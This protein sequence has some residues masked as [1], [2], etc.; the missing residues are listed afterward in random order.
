MT[1]LCLFGKLA[2]KLRES[3]LIINDDSYQPGGMMQ[4]VGPKYYLGI[5]LCLTLLISS[6]NAEAFSLS[7]FD[8]AGYLAYDG[9]G[10]VV[11]R[12]GLDPLLSYENTGMYFNT[13][14]A[15]TFSFEYLPTF[16]SVEEILGNPATD[17]YWSATVRNLRLPCQE[18]A[19]PEFTWSYV[20]SYADLLDGAN[21]AENTYDQ[22]MP[23]EFVYDFGY[24]FDSET[25]GTA[26]LNLAANFD[27]SQLP[28]EFPDSYF[29]AYE[30]GLE[31]EVH[32]DPIPENPVPEPISLVM[33]GTGLIG[34]A[35]IRRS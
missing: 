25:T 23:D 24:R 20:G 22:F 7:G 15:L 18:F 34:V 9:N 1:D 10:D 21:W 29:G 16:P 11:S 4:T 3:C 5:I 27:V 8:F 31:I 33:L 30:S 35:I 12:F 2:R 26:W 13:A 28:M 6:G 19:I 14:A 32:A 17:W